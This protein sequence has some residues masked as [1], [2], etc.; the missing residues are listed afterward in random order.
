MRMTVDRHIRPAMEIEALPP[1]P[2]A[3]HFVGIGGIGMSGLARIL[4][5][6]GYRVTG[7]DA[8]ESDQTEALRGLGVPVDIGHGAIVDVAAAA[9]V[10]MTAAVG[11][12]NPEVVAARAAG[13]PTVK[14]ADLLGLLANG[15][16]G[17]AVAGSHGKS[18]TSGMLVVALRELGADP[19]YA[20]GAT[21]RTT[22]ANAAPGSGEIMV[23]EADEYDHS[24]LA[25]RPEVAIVTNLDYDHPDIF[26]DQAAYDAAFAAFVA[27]IRPGGT[28]VVAGDDPG[29]ARLLNRKDAGS[30]IVTFGETDAVDWRLGE[31]DAGWTVTG[32]DGDT[33]ALL[34]GVHGRHNARNATAALAACVALGF[35]REAV[36]RALGRFT[37]VGRR[38]ELKG[39]A[40]GV[41]VIDDYA[42]HPSEIRATIAAAR[43]RYPEGRIWAVFQPH[44]YSRTKALLD[45]FAE[46]LTGADRIAVL[47][48]YAAREKETLGVSAADL[49][50]KLPPETLGAEGPA[51]AAAV[52]ARRVKPGD[53]VL[54][55]G[56]GDIT[57]MGPRLLELLRAR[58]SGT[59][60]STPRRGSIE[61]VPGHSDLKVWRHTSLSTWTTW[62]V[63]GP[64]DVLVRA[65]TPD[66]L[67]AALAWGRSEGMPI[68]VIGGGSNL[69]V[70]DNG[71]RGLVILA[72][73]P[74]ERADDL[75]QAT[76]E[77]EHISLR[78]NAQ[79][80][81]SWVGRYACERGWA[82]LG[83]GVVLPG[84]IGGA[85]VNNAGAHATELKDVFDHVVVVDDN[86]IRRAFDKI[87]LDAS[88]RMT[89]LKCENRPRSI[90]VVETI[91][92]LSKGNR[93]S[94][95]ALADDHAA[96]RKRTQPTGACAGSTFAN[97][98]GDFAG[99]LLEDAGLKG[100]RIGGAQFSPKHANWIVNTGG[101]TATDIRALIAHAR[102]TV[103]E[104]HGIDL[105]PEVEELGEP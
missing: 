96:F 13:V 22:G 79:A 99:R 15:R 66:G 32:P 16:R 14:R 91:F 71:V 72:R 46:A 90:T 43:R 50:A 18:T 74:G 26:K 6:W 68:T 67:M 58:P 4:L 77:D 44:T 82:G 7:S 80:P 36:A 47:E 37:G 52:L 10:V 60:G 51:E 35:E 41:T 23:V 17:V 2:A 78:V 21:V 102:K 69:L 31:D 87:W 105:R 101:A 85:T 8:Q 1:S 42:H 95:I 5:T 39:E 84:T 63:G 54:G 100:R 64:A 75:V 25:L 38:F 27:Q 86:N 89:R 94:L 70:G 62:R 88:Y 40:N 98:P 24:F 48:I 53:V 83:W 29:C 59:G 93:D 73:T 97:P 65:A 76:D 20:V 33:A 57:H 34:L 56:A 9:L 45:D 11:E 49:R 61:T 81:L 28:L 103:L 104:R 92:R 3:V 19:S 12:T 30:R 55:L